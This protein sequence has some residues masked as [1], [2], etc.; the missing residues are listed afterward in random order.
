MRSAYIY[1]FGYI[2]VY[3]GAFFGLVVYPLSGYV[4]YTLCIMVATLFYMTPYLAGQTPASMILS[5]MHRNKRMTKEEILA[6][7]SEEK[8]IK[9]RIIDLKRA[10]LLRQDATGISMSSFGRVVVALTRVY[11]KIFNSA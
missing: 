5:A 11:Q 7:F 3:I 1:V 8:L 6:L 9:K 2:G 4:M 10:G